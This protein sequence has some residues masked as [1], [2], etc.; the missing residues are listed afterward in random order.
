MRSTRMKCKAARHRTQPISR[1]PSKDQLEAE[2]NLPRRRRRGGYHPSRRADGAA[3][4]D[5]RVRS[6]EIR[7]IERVEELRS[8]LQSSPLGERDVFEEREVQ[9]RQPRAIERPAAESHIR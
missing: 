5:G 6:A 1:E 2:L 3:G 9:L 8:E 7:V 4:K